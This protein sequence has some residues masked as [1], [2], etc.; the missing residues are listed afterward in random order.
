VADPNP[1][2]PACLRHMFFFFFSISAVG[3]IN[4]GI[5]RSFCDSG[6]FAVIIRVPLH[7]TPHLS[8]RPR[9]FENDPE[10]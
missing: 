7:S 5:F 3:M 9:L 6:V 4:T 2:L 8:S 1:A 10:Q